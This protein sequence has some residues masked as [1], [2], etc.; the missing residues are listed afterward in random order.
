MSKNNYPLADSA[1][2]EERPGAVT[3]RHLRC[4]ATGEFRAPKKGEWYLSGA[5]IAGYKAPSDLSYPFHIA[6][7]VVCPGTKRAAAAPHLWANRK[8]IGSTPA[9]FDL[10]S[11]VLHG[12]ETPLASAIVPDL[13]HVYTFLKANHP[14]LIM[15]HLG[16]DISAADAVK[17]C[18]HLAH[19][20]KSA[21]VTSRQ[22]GAK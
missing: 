12:E 4:V 18:W 6:K 8:T 1:T 13:W 7:L 3:Q 21:L 19:S 9:A 15:S 5:I 14:E 11:I 22:R 20:L 17:E 2:L 10:G 16:K